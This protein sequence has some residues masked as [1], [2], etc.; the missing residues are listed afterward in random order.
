MSDG[1]VFPFKTRR[2]CLIFVAR[3]VW[4]RRWERGLSMALRLHRAAAIRKG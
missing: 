4:E 2:F 3:S 1:W